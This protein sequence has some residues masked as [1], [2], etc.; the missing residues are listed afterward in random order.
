MLTSFNTNSMVIDADGSTNSFHQPSHQTFGMNSHNNFAADPIVQN[1]NSS[2]PSHV[3]DYMN[4]VKENRSVYGNY[5]DNALAFDPYK[6][7]KSAF[8]VVYET[9][10]YNPWG[11][12]GGGAPKLDNSGQLKTKIVGTLRWNLSKL[13]RIFFIC[14]NKI[15]YLFCFSMINKMAR[16]KMTE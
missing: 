11:K 15:F 1:G 3:T 14:F 12:P 7:Q 10:G 6:E 8:N 4:A 2:Y 13:F 9:D 5:V 16:R